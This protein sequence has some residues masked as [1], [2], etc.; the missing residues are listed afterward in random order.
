MTHFK[1]LKLEKC[2]DCDEIATQQNTVTKLFFCD[3]CVEEIESKIESP[4]EVESM[5]TVSLRNI[6]LLKR[7]INQEN[8]SFLFRNSRH[9][10]I[11]Q[12]PDFKSDFD[13]NVPFKGNSLF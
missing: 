7:N 1:S 10:S 5:N 2:N 6:L 4:E 13:E 11:V 12:P 3:D 9:I 8:R